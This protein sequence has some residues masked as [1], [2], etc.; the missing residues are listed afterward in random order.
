M[1]ATN[2]PPRYIPVLF[3]SC[4]SFVADM[5]E[6][7][8]KTKRGEISGLFAYPRVG[9]SGPQMDSP[10]T[11]RSCTVTLND[12]IYLFC[13]KQRICN[14]V[15]TVC[16]HV[17]IVIVKQIIPQES[18]SAPARGCGI[19]YSPTK[20]QSDINTNKSVTAHVCKQI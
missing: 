17:V 18:L 4:V 13:N 9:R 20:K 14:N 15:H 6:I 10:G 19:I 3:S 7:D 11:Y 8:G 12:F 1:V 5:A 2:E 16:F